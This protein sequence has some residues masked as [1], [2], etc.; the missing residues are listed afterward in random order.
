VEAA[1]H[2]HRAREGNPA[3]RI[4][5]ARREFSAPEIR[6]FDSGDYPIQPTQETV[7]AMVAEYREAC[8]PNSC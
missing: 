2:D 7:D 8:S 3:R 6:F 1:G 4:D 5:T